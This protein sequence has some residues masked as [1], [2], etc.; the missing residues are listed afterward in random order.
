M[1]VTARR[2]LSL[3][4]AIAFL[5]SASAVAALEIRLAYIGGTEGSAWLGVMQGQHEANIQ[6][7][8]LDQ[9]YVVEA[10]TVEALSQ[11]QA[12]IAAIIASGDTSELQD[13]SAA[14]NSVAVFNVTAG[15]DVLRQAC[16]T[17]LLNVPPSDAMKAD[18]VAQ[19]REKNPD[20]DVEAWAWHPKFVKYA[21]R[22]LNKRF[23]R[24]QGVAMDDD[25]WA[26]WAAVRMVAEGVIRTQSTDPSTLLEFMK[27]EIAFDG[28]KG[29]PLAFRDTGQ[30]RQ[31]LLIVEGGKLAGEAPV[32]GVVDTTNLDSLG[33][34][35]CQP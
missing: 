30:L 31:R 25:G 3:S 23:L 35:T 34:P 7:R 14:A 17:N 10:M 26:G 28:Q 1:R 27:S 20:A 21:A 16:T 8:F 32:R 13:L 4:A 24:V 29:M 12:P 19:W 33:V 18:A 2:L 15:D 22:D 5:S 6:G 11:S 9:N